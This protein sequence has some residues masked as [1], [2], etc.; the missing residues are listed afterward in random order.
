M[1]ELAK[2]NTYL[3]ELERSQTEAP[4]NN[5]KGIIAASYDG[6]TTG[7]HWLYYA[8][9][10]IGATAWFIFAENEY[11]P[12]WGTPTIP[13]PDISVNPTSHD[14]GS[15]DVGDTSQAQ[16]FTLTNSGN[17]D[18]VIGILSITGRDSSDFIIHNDSCSAQTIAPF[19][20]CMV[21]VVFSP[22]S[23]GSKSASL[24]IQSNDP[25]TPT[26]NIPL[27][28]TGTDKVCF[29]ATAAYGS[30]FHSYVR[31]L[32][33]FRD[34]YLMPYKLGRTFVR[35]YYKYSPVIADLIAEHNVLK[36]AV[37]ISLLPLVSFSYSMLNFGP[38]ITADVLILIFVLPIFSIWF[39]RR[40]LRRVET[41]DPKALASLD[42]KRQLSEVSALKKK[43]SDG[44]GNSQYLFFI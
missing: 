34:T 8:R 23:G 26:L 39:F 3:S 12:Y 43:I 22:T 36:I 7:F 14:F 16:T 38:I 30:A 5:G 1:G 35:F 37:Q 33:D 19:G 11:N 17:V 32:R 20:T 24:S 28:G 4:N 31:T 6:L 44:E 15:L 21:D 9:L 41:K 10:H 18:L 27:S 29:I 25:N 40:R 2:A 13:K 42:W